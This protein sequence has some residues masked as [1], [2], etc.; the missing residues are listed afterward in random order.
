MAVK[1]EDAALFPPRT[2]A[3][4]MKNGT[5]GALRWFAEVLKVDADDS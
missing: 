3:I 1:C 2:F 4:I 5:Y